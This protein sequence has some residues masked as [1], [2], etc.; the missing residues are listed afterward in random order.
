MEA[1]GGVKVFK[2]NECDWWVAKDIDSAIKAYLADSGVSREDIPDVRELTD[3]EMDR[4]MYLPADDESGNSLT[5]RQ[6]LERM[7]APDNHQFR[8]PEVFAS[9]EF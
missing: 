4:M 5:F 7:T 1:I 6:V 3:E 2:M 8:H 9:T